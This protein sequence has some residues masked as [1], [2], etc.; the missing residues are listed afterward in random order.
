MSSLTMMLVQFGLPLLMGLA[1]VLFLR[2]ALY[3]LLCDLCQTEARALFWERVI[4]VLML[5]APLALVLWFGSTVA[6][7]PW[8][9][10]RQTMA[11]SL[12][13]VVLA[14]CMVAWQMARYI[15]HPLSDE[16]MPLAGRAGQ[17]VRT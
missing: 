11:L 17:G 4:G 8:Q 13:G 14:L 15:P 2:R 16:P 10:L 5:V 7:N 3:R 12:T 1:V 9:L 6:D